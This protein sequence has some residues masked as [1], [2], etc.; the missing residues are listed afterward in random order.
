MGYGMPMPGM[1]MP[2][3]IAP[4]PGLPMGMLP[5]PAAANLPTRVLK[6]SH[7]V[8]PIE[9][10]DDSEYRDIKEDVKEECAQHGRV[11]QVVIPRIKDGFSAAA[12]GHIFVEFE[13]PQSAALCSRALAGRKFSDRLVIV[14]YYDERAYASR[15]YG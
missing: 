10:Q 14:E 3:P 1:P 2:L 12:E 4:M 13:L 5:V 7:M 11:V 6:L 15:I 8:T 9:L